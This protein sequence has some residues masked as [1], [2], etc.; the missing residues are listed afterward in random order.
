MPPSYPTLF[1]FC[2]KWWLL[3]RLRHTLY[4]CVYA[5]VCSHSHPYATNGSPVHREQSFLKYTTVFRIPP[6]APLFSSL[7]VIAPLFGWP[8]WPL[9]YLWI[10]ALDFPSCLWGHTHTHRPR[11][12]FILHLHNASVGSFGARWFEAASFVGCGRAK[13]YATLYASARSRSRPALRIAFALHICIASD[14][15]FGVPEIPWATTYIKSDFSSARLGPVAGK[16]LRS[17]NRD[18]CVAY[19]YNCVKKIR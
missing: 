16:A 4:S 19:S 15:Q 6:L 2:A 10:F 13:W 1:M 9:V 3:H 12:G 5:F 17:D 8:G 11:R 7:S 14:A 18:L